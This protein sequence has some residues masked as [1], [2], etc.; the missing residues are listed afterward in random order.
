MGAQ[1]I[2]PGLPGPKNHVETTVGNFKVRFY[3]TALLNIQG[4]D[5][6]IVGQDVPLWAAPDS[7]AVNYPDGSIGRAGDNHDLLFSVRQSVLGVTVGQA[8]SSGWSPSA[9]VEVDFFGPRTADNFQ[10]LNR[11]LNAPRLRVGYLQ[12]E[13]NDWKIVAGQDKMILAPLDPVSLSHVAIPLGG[14]AGNLWAWLPQVRVDW[15]HKMGNTGLLVQAGIL[16][17]L[18]G[19]PKLTGDTITAGS[20]ID[21]GSSGFGSRSTQP[22]YQ[23][24]VAVSPQFGGRTSTIGVSGHFGQEKVG[25]GHNLQSWAF[26]IDMNARLERHVI[27]KGEGFVGSNLIP[28]EGGIAQGAAVQGGKIQRIG[29]AGGWLELTVFPKPGGNGVLYFGAGT[30]DPKNSNLLPGSTRT[31]N[32]FVWASY[33]RRLTESVT[34]AVEWSNWQFQTGAFSGNNLLKGPTG[35]SN[36]FDLSLAY[37]F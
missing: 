22:F 4:S 16:D 15:N 34:L 10:A 32:S 7:G 37:Q 3:G 26:A 19:D 35:S 25:V 11:V 36:V 33:F 30:D 31:K 8:K 1:P 12:L 6:A 24:R 13:H 14:T 21:T 27:L 28:F 18:F 17:P 23:A 29:A 9:L 2:Y 5:S 20:A